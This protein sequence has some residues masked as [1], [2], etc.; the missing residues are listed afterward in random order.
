MKKSFKFAALTVL[1]FFVTATVFEPLSYARAGGGRSFGGG[2]SFGSS[3]SRPNSF[4]QPK[5]NTSSQSQNRGGLL[6][7]IGGGIVGGM[8]GSMLFRS[9][10]FGGGEG[11]GLLQI[12]IFAGLGYLIFRFIRS[13]MARQAPES[14]SQSI[15]SG[16]LFKGS[17]APADS[18]QSGLSAIKESDPS[19]TEKDFKDNVM[20]IF[21]KVQAAW[22]NRDLSSASHLLDSKMKDYLQS[23]VDQLLSSGKIN[24]LENIAVRNINID[25]AWQESDTECITALIYANLLD[26]TVDEKNGNVV[27]GSRTEPVKFE[28]YWT[29]YRPIGTGNWKLSGINQ[30]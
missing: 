11:G 23:D 22:M 4:S 29:F 7:S 2:K 27:E 9:L 17:S 12:L 13:R 18:Q 26:Y 25:E 1:V 6:K 20:D 19:F 24:R 8:L 21:F 30:I 15:S 28:E 10:G 14:N 3:P 16:G 5:S